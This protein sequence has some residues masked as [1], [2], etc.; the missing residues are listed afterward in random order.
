[1]TNTNVITRFTDSGIVVQGPYEELLTVPGL[2]WSKA[3]SAWC[4][5]FSPSLAQSLL[6]TFTGRLLCNDAQRLKDLAAQEGETGRLRAIGSDLPDVPNARLAP[7]PHQ[8]LE[9]WAMVKQPALLAYLGLG[10]GKTAPVVWYVQNMHVRT[11]L[12]ACPLS[13]VNVWLS[14]FPKHA[15]VSVAIWHKGEVL[16][17]PDSILVVPLDRGSVAEK[18]KIVQEVRGYGGPIVFVCNYESLW[19]EPLA[20]TFVNMTLDLLVMDEG[21]KLQSPGS[22]VSKFFHSLAK[23]VGKRVALTGTPCPN[24]PLTIYGLYRALDSGVFGTSFARFREQY[25]VMGGYQNHEILGY[26]N[27]EE[28]NKRFYSIAIHADRSVLSLPPAVTVQRTSSLSPSAMKIYRSLEKDL[29]AEIEQGT[30]TAANGLVKLLRLS[31][32]TGGWLTPDVD[33]FNPEAKPQRVDSAKKELLADVLDDLPKEEPVVVFYRFTQDAESIHVVCI[34]QG[35]TYHELSGR[36]NSLGEWQKNGQV[37]AVQIAT[38]GLGVDLTR[39][40]YC[41]Y[42]SVGYSL[43]EYEQSMARVHRPGQERAVTY[44]Q[45]IMQNT[46]DEKVYAA[47]AAKHDVVEMVLREIKEADNGND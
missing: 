11:T 38:G 16:W 15:T 46:V 35:R 27:V 31:Q 33:V 18:N 29:M 34:E 23:T 21:H 2:S 30:V 1:V 25:A 13:V 28:Y 10:T 14:E 43:S 41:I 17:P 12:V 7:W 32:L 4:G 3:R 44:V 5:D 19:R 40:C 22:R 42:Y 8:K 6:R 36:A 39:A 20:K 24:G 37:L 47:L 9:Y 26:K 45:L